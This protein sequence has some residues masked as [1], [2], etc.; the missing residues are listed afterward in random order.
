MV[1][2]DLQDYEVEFVAEDREGKSLEIVASTILS[3]SK[4]SA[5]ILSSP[6]SEAISRVGLGSKRD[7]TLPKI[8]I[9]VSD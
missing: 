9:P 6:S 7:S 3:N 5:F 2:H 8:S 4:V 1:Y